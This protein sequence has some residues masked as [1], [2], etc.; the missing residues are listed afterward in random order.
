ML[1][2]AISQALQNITFDQEASVLNE[3]IRTLLDALWN[4]EI[5]N[6]IEQN[7]W[8]ILLFYLIPGNDIIKD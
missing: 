7:E 5:E 8:F 4:I 2:L 6:I 3:F 1:T